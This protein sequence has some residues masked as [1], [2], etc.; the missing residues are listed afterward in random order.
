M[1]LGRTLHIWIAEPLGGVDDARVAAL[2]QVLSP[3]ERA[4]AGRHAR[5]G[6]YQRTVLSRFMARDVLSRYV[7]TTPPH[8]WE[9]EAGEHGK[10]AVVAPSAA[11]CFNV[12]HTRD[13][14]VMLV[15]DTPCGIDVEARD[16]GGRL[17]DV[18]ERFFAAP[19]SAAMRGLQADA[20]RRRFLETWTL[21]EAFVKALGCG[22]SFTLLKQFWF[23]FDPPALVIEPGAELPQTW[24]FWQFEP[25]PGYVLGAA[26]P[27]SAPR[28]LRLWRYRFGAEPRA[29]QLP[30]IQT[31]SL[32]A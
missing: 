28:P 16:R 19:E 20:A 2:A 5:S 31:F 14:I 1:L 24:R 21:K 30:A 6:Q 4:R 27:D 29:E 8:A 32:P 22:L 15:A 23:N 12:S 7:P 18:A 17:D 26:L 11:P 25:A 9:F 3:A 13:R 10:P